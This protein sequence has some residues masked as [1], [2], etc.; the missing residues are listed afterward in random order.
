MRKL[1]GPFSQI[2]TLDKLP[3][4]GALS[5]SQLEIVENGGVLT[6]DRKIV[7]VGDFEALK[8]KADSFEEI[9]EEAVLLPGFV[10]AHTHICFG[11]SRAK[12]YAM[13]VAG[14]PYLEIAR[15]GGGIQSSVNKT[16]EASLEELIDGVSL[17]ANRH[18]AQ[19]V[20]TTEVKSGYGL[21][22]EHEVKMLRAIKEANETGK[23]DLISTCLAAHTKP[24]DFDGDN[25]AYLDYVAN[26]ILP[27]VKEQ[28]LSDRVDI[29]T[30]ETAFTVA[31]SVKYLNQAKAMGFDITVHADQFTSGAGTMAAELGAL[32]ADHLENS[33]SE[34]INALANSDTVAVALPGA[35]LGLGMVYTPGRKL[36]DAGACLAIASDWNPGSA[37]MGH[38]LMQAAVF[39]AA[40]K[41]STAEVLAALTCRASKALKLDDRGVLATGKLADFQAYPCA[42]YREILYHQG[43][44]APSKVWKN[45]ELVKG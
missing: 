21:S 18:L 43:M 36:L 9:K 29:F 39:G 12:D 28:G 2:L 24:K 11:G 19:G 23:A 3:D 17:R 1:I 15:A 26:E 20:T 4:K 22:L 34:E 16:R 10:D 5:D 44:M 31:Q 6:E 40:E 27:V 45:S 41:L 33:G 14:V 42:D 32:S 30:E 35:S 25:E 8:P 7:A 13:R 37:P 38:L